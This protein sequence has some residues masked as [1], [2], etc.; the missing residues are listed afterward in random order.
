MCRQAR[1][2]LE[3][4]SCLDVC[5][6]LL[7]TVPPSFL[8]CALLLLF[9]TRLL[10]PGGAGKRSPPHQPYSP[11]HQNIAAHHLPRL[12]LLLWP[13]KLNV[14]AYTTIFFFI[15]SP[16]THS[17]PRLNNGCFCC[18]MT[19]ATSTRVRKKSCS[20]IGQLTCWSTIKSPGHTPK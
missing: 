8:K 6:I 5:F 7:Y 3:G 17:D 16:M 14:V 11:S 18:S 4:F 20:C 10:S 19:A 9:L 15:M 1:M 2:V 12:W 13:I